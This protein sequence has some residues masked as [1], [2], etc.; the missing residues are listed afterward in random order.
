[1]SQFNGHFHLSSRARRRPIDP[2]ATGTI[3]HGVAA[4][5]RAVPLIAR[6]RASALSEL[7]RRSAAPCRSGCRTRIGCRGLARWFL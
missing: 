6:R 2:L 7:A 1:M 4:L 3:G 5:G